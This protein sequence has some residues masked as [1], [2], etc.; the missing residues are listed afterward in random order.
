RFPTIRATK[1]C[2]SERGRTAT[3]R[4][5]E[6]SCRKAHSGRSRQK[7]L[8]CCSTS[9]FAIPT[10]VPE[11]RCRCSRPGN[12]HRREPRDWPVVPPPPQCRR[13][14]AACA[15]SAAQPVWRGRAGVRQ[16]VP[17]LL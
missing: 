13:E 11:K 4:L 7:L 14:T 15:G 1:E 5:P 8:P 2:R 12:E 9:A 3:K 17:S 6:Y 16:P 10:E